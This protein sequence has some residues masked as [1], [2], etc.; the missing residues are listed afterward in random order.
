[1]TDPNELADRYVA[2]WNEPDPE[3]RH[4]AV[5]QL[6]SDAGMQILQPPQEIRDVAATLAM[7]PIL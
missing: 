6:W 5:K 3:R 2:I 4:A 7:S 1:M